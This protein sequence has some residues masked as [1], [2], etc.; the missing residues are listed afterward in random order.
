VVALETDDVFTTAR[1]DRIARLTAE[2]L[3]AFRAYVLSRDLYR[4][5]LVSVD[6][7]TT[8]VA[9]RIE[10]DVDKPAVAA[11]IRRTVEG[12]DLPERVYY[13]GVPFQL[14]EISR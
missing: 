8:L 11:D 3:A 9:A 5:R 13:A 1:L 4:S 6:G 12:A 10:E 7:T 2:Q 14:A